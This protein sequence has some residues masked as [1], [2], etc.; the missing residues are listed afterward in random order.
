MSSAPATGFYGKLPCKGDF[1]QRRVP[2]E[3]VDVWDSWLQAGLHATRTRLAERWLDAYLTGPI[4]RFVLAQGACGTSS[5]AGLM[6]P[7]VDRVGRYFPLAIVA[8]LEDDACLIDIAGAAGQPWYDAVESLA[9][10]ALQAPDLDLDSFDERLAA[11]P[12]PAAGPSLQEAT[13]LMGAMR[14]R[15]FVHGEG[16]WHVSLGSAFSLARTAAVFASLEWQRALRPLAL[17]WTDGSD[18]VERC[19]LLSRGLPPAEQFAALFAGGFAA[20]GWPSISAGAPDVPAACAPMEDSARL[21]PPPTSSYSVIDAPAA[22]LE[23]AAFNPPVRRMVDA[24]SSVYFTSRPELWLWGLA[25]G[26][27]AAH[28]PDRAQRVMDAVCDLAPSATLTAGVE[29]VRRSLRSSVPTTAGA[30]AGGSPGAGEGAGEG[31]G[32]AAAR[33][34]GAIFFLSRDNECA[35]VGF[36]SMRAVRLRASRAETIASFAESRE[37]RSPAQPDEPGDTG[38]LA[39]L[40]APGQTQSDVSVHYEALEAGDLWLL[41]TESLLEDAQ[42]PR[43]TEVLTEEVVAGGA[44][45]DALCGVAARASE[46]AQEL[47]VMLL[48]VRRS[49]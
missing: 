44:A 45:L 42:V 11:L 21:D 35:L 15:S 12:A 4:W 20:S 28:E 31:A 32:A 3:F 24:R 17:W 49:A 34:L 22:P 29:A 33:E 46:A 26:A 23:I 39:L 36:G 10:E 8:P 9:L 30:V 43:I 40:S 37:V 41:G 13:E 38:L 18:T 7:S 5:C 1:I 6:L 48:S 2:Q 19:S 25:Y 14:A 47:P 16:R 27:R